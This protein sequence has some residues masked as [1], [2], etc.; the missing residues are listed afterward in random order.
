MAE[1][2]LNKNKYLDLLGLQTFWNRVK[3]VIL[4]SI[5]I[6]REGVKGAGNGQA[7]DNTYIKIYTDSSGTTEDGGQKFIY[8]VDET[9]LV[10][11]LGSVDKAITDEETARK[12]DVAL[13]A[14]TNWNTSSHTWSSAPKY[15][16]ISKISELLVT[17]DGQI[18]ALVQAT[19][20]VGVVDWNP[21]AADVT[22][23]ADPDDNTQTIQWF[24]VKVGG[25]SKGK[26]RAGDIVVYKEKEFILDGDVANGYKNPNFVELGDVTAEQARLSAIETW[27]NTPINGDDINKVFAGTVTDQNQ[28]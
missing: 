15:P 19:E 13:L 25:K 2:N 26:F 6:V 20:F 3:D 5:V 7:Q 10:E 18:E 28:K 22:I 14:G 9:P 1:I 8:T 12:A 17:H 11:K 24:E 16:D 23:I 21:D 27:I 4:H